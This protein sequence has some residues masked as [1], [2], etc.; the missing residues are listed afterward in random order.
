MPASLRSA[1]KAK[2]FGYFVESRDIQRF[3]KVRVTDVLRHVPGVLVTADMRRGRLRNTVQMRDGCLPTLWLDGILMRG[4]DLD[5]IAGA[6]DLQALEVYTS[7]ATLPIE[8]RA[9]DS[10]EARSSLG[11]RASSKHAPLRT[12]WTK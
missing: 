12:K 10:T 2:G 8:F 6:D 1:C 5:E 9:S 7:P 11:R 4:T 3:G